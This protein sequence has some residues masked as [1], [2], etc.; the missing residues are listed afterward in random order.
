MR[1]WP[2]TSHTIG[3]QIGN[4]GAANISRALQ[5]NTSLK[6][7]DISG[8]LVF[9]FKHVSPNK[10]T[11]LEILVLRILVEHF[12]QTLHSHHLLFPVWL[13][14]NAFHT[15]VNQIGYSGAESISRALQSNTSLTSLVISGV[16]L[17]KRLSHNS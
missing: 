14:S 15:T 3:N 12:N 5:S 7:L 10:A 17:F 13:C 1:C 11:I 2:N 4:S 9:L 6:S 16:L 8:V